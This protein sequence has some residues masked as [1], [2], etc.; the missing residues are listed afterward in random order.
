MGGEISI[1]SVPLTN[2]NDL[3][4]ITFTLKMPVRT[5]EEQARIKCSL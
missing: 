1:T 4:E 3:S 5:L 2:Q